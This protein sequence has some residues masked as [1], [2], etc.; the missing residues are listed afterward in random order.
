MNFIKTCLTTCAL[1]ATLCVGLSLITGCQLVYKHEM[2]QG[3]IIPEDKLSELKPGLTMAQVHFLLG[4]PILDN[5]L[6]QDR[7]DYIYYLKPGYKKAERKHLVI[8]FKDEKVSELI[9]PS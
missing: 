9:L 8:Y 1:L 2:T 6:H 5:Y 3:N 7:W 4:T